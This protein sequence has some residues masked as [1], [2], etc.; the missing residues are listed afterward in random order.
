M[1]K[2]LAVT[3]D[4]P[5]L[6]LME[7]PSQGTF[8]QSCGMYLTKDDERAHNADGSLSDD[9]CVWCGVEGGSNPDETMEELIER[10][11]PFMVESGSFKSVDE[12]VSLLGAVLP[13]LKRWQ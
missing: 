8:C 11:A 1:V 6:E 3:L 2:L 7:L 13:H 9:W 10:C 12:A 4:V 5:V